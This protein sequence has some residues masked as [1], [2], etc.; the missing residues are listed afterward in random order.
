MSAAT[1]LFLALPLSLVAVAVHAETHDVRVRNFQFIPNELEIQ[2]GDTV[3]WIGEEGFHNVRADDDS[4][5]NLA[6]TAPWTFE[7]TFTTAGDVR[8]YC[9]VHSTPGQPIGSAMNGLIHVVGEDPPPFVINQGMAGSWYN[10]ATN[11][12]GFLIDLLPATK[13]IFVAW[14]T[15]EKPVAMPVTGNEPK[16]GAPEQ[17]WMTA[18][19]TYNGSGASLTLYSNSSGI[20][21]S[22]APVT[23]TPVG[24]VA[25]NFSDCTHGSVTYSIPGESQSGTIPI[26][27]G[28]TGIAQICEDLRNPAPAG[29]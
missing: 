7:H 3:R 28:N 2:V 23:V 8:Y 17:R 21:N 6:A 9:D 11:G 22:N 13:F 16:I 20:F 19:G 18:S 5:Q 26:E 29:S 4:F 25:L 27:R 14:F 24:T 12:Q 1:R 10:P 15:Y